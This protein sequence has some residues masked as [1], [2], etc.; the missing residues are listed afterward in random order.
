M[1]LFTCYSFF[2]FPYI[3]V[4]NYYRRASVYLFHFFSFVPDF[5]WKVIPFPV[6]SSVRPRWQWRRVPLPLCGWRVTSILISL[7]GK[8]RRRQSIEQIIIINLIQSKLIYFSAIDIYA[9]YLNSRSMIDV[10]SR[11]CSSMASCG[12]KECAE[13]E[14]FIKK[15]STKRK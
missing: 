3:F 2:D 12:D 4:T 1:I 8:S 6:A 9:S 10:T 11:R 7:H 13:R 5:S 14:Y 15:L